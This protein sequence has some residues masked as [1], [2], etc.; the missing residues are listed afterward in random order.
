MMPQMKLS[1]FDQVTVG[2]RISLSGNPIAQ[3]GDLSGEVSPV[4]VQPNAAVDIVID[5]AVQ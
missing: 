4:A 3:T 2:A 5:S 1:N